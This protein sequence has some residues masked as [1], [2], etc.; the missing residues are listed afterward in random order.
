M[1]TPSQR[2]PSKVA[3]GTNTGQFAL[4]NEDSRNLGTLVSFLSPSH[5]LTHDLL[6][7]GGSP[8]RRWTV[9][10]DVEEV[11]ATLAGLS[12]EI[13]RLLSDSQRLSSALD[14]T[15][16]TVLKKSDHG[17]ALDET[18]VSRVRQ[19]LSEEQI[20]Y[21]K[22]QALIVAYRAVSWKYIESRS[23][24]YSHRGYLGMA[25]SRALLTSDTATSILL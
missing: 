18:V 15:S 25:S 20:S 16:T 2:G 23:V 7:R 3:S 1:D 17:F 11:D 19:S 8:R 10:G 6:H 24:C 13:T 5:E 22:C 21:W 4:H 14:D 9:R 12:K